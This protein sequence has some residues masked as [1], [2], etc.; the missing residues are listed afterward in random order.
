M[1][2][3]RTK[4]SKK[5]KKNRGEKKKK[6]KKKKKTPH[7][8]PSRQQQ[9]SPTNTTPSTGSFT[10]RFSRIGVFLDMDA[11]FDGYVNSLGLCF[12]RTRFINLIGADDDAM[13]G[14]CTTLRDARGTERP[15]YE[16]CVSEYKKGAIVSIR[17]GDF[18]FQADF[19]DPVAGV[20]EAHQVQEQIFGAS[21]DAQP[22]SSYYWTE[23]F[24]AL[25]A[26][27]ASGKYNVVM[28][29]GGKS[30]DCDPAGCLYI[31]GNDHVFA[32]IDM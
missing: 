6:K 22:P 27:P 1:A 13:D 19:L 25:V 2:W 4:V 29:G 18:Y 5:S 28:R 14:Y 7:L 21:C 16:Y 9:H 26:D 20:W 31:S 17:H 23:M 15:Y 8:F 30:Q 3:R 12:I 11:R 10:G 32:S 24:W